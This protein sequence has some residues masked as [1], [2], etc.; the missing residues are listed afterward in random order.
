MAGRFLVSGRYTDERTHPHIIVRYKG[1][2]VYQRFCRVLIM[3]GD[4][5]KLL[6]SMPLTLQ[7]AE[8][9]G[10][11]G[12]ENFVKQVWWDLENEHGARETKAATHTIPSLEG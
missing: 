7:A 2:L 4:L 12:V 5:G 9:E 6:N 10:R 8:F 3:P 1:V 11:R